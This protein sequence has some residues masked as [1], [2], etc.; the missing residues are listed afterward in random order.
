MSF[1]IKSIFSFIRS[2]YLFIYY[3][4]AENHN[5]ACTKTDKSKGL[6]YVGLF[7]IPMKLMS[8]IVILVYFVDSAMIYLKLLSQ[9]VL[10]SYYKGD[11]TGLVIFA[12][13]LGFAIA[14][15]ICCHRIVYKDIP[16]RLDKHPLFAK[17][18]T[19]KFLALE[20]FPLSIFMGIALL[21]LINFNGTH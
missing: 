6:I 12:G 8:L 17:Y 13:L 5:R 15:M 18:S 2:Y 19:K 14:Y 7:L 20:F 16:A 4:T 10:F 9:Y 3:W 11:V 21:C 1:K